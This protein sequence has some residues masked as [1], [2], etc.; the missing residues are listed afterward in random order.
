MNKGNIKTPILAGSPL[1]VTWH[2]GYP[3]GGELGATTSGQLTDG[4][5]TAGLFLQSKASKSLA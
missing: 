4:R 2:L 5:I 1:T 3:H